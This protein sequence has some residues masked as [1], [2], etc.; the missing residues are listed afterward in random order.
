M[1]IKKLLRFSL[2]LALTNGFAQ[3]TTEIEA[4]DGL[5]YV[6]H[7]NIDFPITGIY[8]F[9]GAE[10]IVELDNGGVGFYQLHEQ[11]KRPVL[12]GIESD[13]WGNLKFKKGFDNT[14][15]ILWYQYTTKLDSD[16]EEDTNWK[17]VEFTIHFNTGKM[18]IQGERSKSYIEKTKK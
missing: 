3:G 4:K 18:F 13:V 1:K 11:L 12:W 7:N 9:K 8:Y 6:T 17:S 10:P 14:K 2:V 15:Y 16:E 5:H